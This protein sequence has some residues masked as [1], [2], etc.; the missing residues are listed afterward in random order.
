MMQ[1]SAAVKLM[2]RPPALVHSRKTNRS[3]SGLENRSMAAC[4]RLPRTLPS[5]RSYG[6]LGTEG[7][8]V[9][10]YDKDIT[11]VKE[12][13]RALLVESFQTFSE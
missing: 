6:Y 10:H 4:R 2:P 3:E 12:D 5:I 9:G 1:V 8:D 13:F 11:E 7:A